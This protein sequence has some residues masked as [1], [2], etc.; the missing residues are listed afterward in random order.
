MLQLR[1]HPALMALKA[2]IVAEPSGI[3]RDVVVTYVTARGPWYMASWKGVEERSGGLATNIGIHFFDLLI[4]LFGS[5]KRVHVN[6]REGRKMAGTLELARA[7]VRWYLSVDV[8]DLP[9]PS[10]GGPKVTYRSI[11]VDGKEIEFT[12]GFADLHTRIYERALRGDGFGIEDAR[13]SIELVHTM[14]TTAL[15]APDHDAHP[16]LLTGSL[17]TVEAAESETATQLRIHEPISAN[18]SE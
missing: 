13:P 3:T 17:K 10:N 14:R 6:L 9:F 8:M 16:Y 1:V 2:Q 5:V 4:W 7:R 12:D 15:T 11:T 18:K